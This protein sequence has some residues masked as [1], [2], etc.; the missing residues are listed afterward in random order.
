M[1]RADGLCRIQAEL[2][3]GALCRTCREFPRLTH[4]FGDFVELG[5]ELSCPEAA[6]LILTAPAELSAE[7]ERPGGEEPEYDR[8]AMAVLLATRDR[9]RQILSDEQRPV[10]ET[11]SLIL[12]YGCQAQGELDSGEMT[13]FDAEKTLKEAEHL[14]RPGNTAEV[15]D[16]FKDLELLTPQ[17]KALLDSPAP[18]PWEKV[19][20][21]LARYLADRYWL[22]AVSDYDLYS[23]VKLLVLSCLVVKSLG[24]DV[25]R[26][27]QLYS[28]EI[29]N[30]A[31][32]VDALL[33]AA[34]GHPAF[35]DDKLLWL[36]KN[37]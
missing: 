9:A 5:L 33:D 17:W 1:W 19:H 23:R 27:A 20:L 10:G 22:Q 2:G 24:G 11:L 36:L 18:A 34:Y 31:S 25:F 6:R 7:E 8:E 12:L 35:T 13:L 37:A 3:E 4:D 29:E 21:A 14:A 32:N 28:K 15:L 26:T 16:F 30:N